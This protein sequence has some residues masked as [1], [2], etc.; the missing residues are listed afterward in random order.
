MTAIAM[1]V[2]REILKP[3]NFLERVFPIPLNVTAHDSEKIMQARSEFAR[4]TDV[5]NM[6]SIEMQDFLLS[7]DCPQ[8]FNHI[9]PD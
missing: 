5:D 7:L 1:P 8:R 6:S 4:V 9:Y 2:H 3:A